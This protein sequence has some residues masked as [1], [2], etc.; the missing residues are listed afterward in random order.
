MLP[1]KTLLVAAGLCACG[2]FN[3]LAHTPAQNEIPTFTNVSVHD[4]SI[5]RDGPEFYVFGSHLASAKTAD[6]M[7]WTQLS[8]GPTDDNPLFPHPFT[9]FA[10]SVN[11]IGNNP[12]F[13]APDAIRL[14]DGRYYFYY[15]I[16]R[17]DQPHAVLGVAVSNNIMGPYTDLGVIVRSGMW[18]QPSLDGTIYDATRHPNAVDP[19]VF[20]DKTGKLWMVYGS[21]SGGIFILQLDATTGMPLPNQGYGKKLIGGNHSRIEGPFTLYSPETDYYYLFLSFGGL[22]ADGGYNIRVARSRQP[23]GPFYDS[24]GNDMTN[25][26]GAPGSFFDDAAI[27]PYGV[28]MMGNYQFRAAPGEPVAITRGYLSPGHNSAYY[29]P[30][31]GKYFLVFHTRFVGRGEE[32][33]VRVHQMYMNSDGW[34]VAAP[35]RYAGETQ[36]RHDRHD[37]TGDYK[38]INHGK[39]ISPALNTSSLITLNPNGSVSGAATGTWDFRRNNAI[40]LTLDG[41]TYNGVFSTQWDDDQGAWVYAFSAL[42][43]DG[44]SLWGSHTVTSQHSPVAVSVPNRLALFGAMNSFSL[45]EP[46]PPSKDPFT[47]SVSDGP[48]G[49]TVDRAPGVV[50]WQPTLSQVDVP[51]PVTIVA[52][53]TSADDP[54]QTRYSFTITARSVNVVRRLDLNF[55]SAATSGLQD[56]TGAFTGFPSRLPGTGSALPA[57]DPNLRLNTTTGSLEL[58]TTQSD[59]NGQAN[60]GIASM[61]GANLSS[62]GFTGSE[63]FAVTAVFKPLTTLEF[64]DQVGVYIGA[65][66]NLMTRADT[67]VFATPERHSTHTQNGTDY[68]G[69][70][71]GF[72]LNAA[73]GMT[74]T[75]TREAGNWRYLIDGLDWNPLSAPSFLDG[76]SDLVAGVFA[77]TPINANRKTIEVD[78]YSLVVA[79]NT[80]QLTPIEAWRI[81]HFGQVENRGIAA[82]SADPDHDGATNLEEFQNGTDP[83]DR[84]S[85]GRHR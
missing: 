48:S 47:Y 30:Q 62:L 50:T 67:I 17:G 9:T 37:V 52:T 54:R 63:D 51:Y 78:S 82:D 34:L 72:G 53:S 29:D 7:H 45:P 49:L 42:S 69:H 66:S 84:T 56:A 18:G 11:W 65:N 76:R 77:I 59:F 41:T 28:K 61:P 81:L 75:I 73:D 46:R 26:S 15:C 10:D 39:A 6:L 23:D 71:F 57:W 4:P 40:T 44:V 85:G 14:A 70:F 24:A 79:T 58:S 60:L 64:I 12:A 35:H 38:I 3:A 8:T 31:S 22:S 19:D 25:V 36:E 21:Y 83:L 2:A 80:P 1:S 55:G 68:D 16:A 20:F 43:S 32:H 13:W 27:A 33:E 74:I 5:V